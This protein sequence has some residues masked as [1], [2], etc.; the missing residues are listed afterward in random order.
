MNRKSGRDQMNANSAP[1]TP[2]KGNALLALP[3]R[4]YCPHRPTPKQ[5]AHVVSTARG[6]LRWSCRSWQD[7]ALLMA[8]LHSVDQPHYRALLLRRTFRQ[9]N[10]SNSIMNRAPEQLANTDAVWNTTDKRFTF[11]SGAIHR[12]FSLLASMN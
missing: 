12:S 4:S 3:P 5:L 2:S 7:R 6:F 11:P 8:A 10:Q 1:T 9:L